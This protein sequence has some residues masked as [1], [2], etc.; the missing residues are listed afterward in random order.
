MLR[1]GCIAIMGFAAPVSLPAELPANFQLLIDEDFEGDFVIEEALDTTDDDA[2]RIF[3]SAGGNVLELRRRSDYKPPVT[4]PLSIALF[5]DVQVGSFVLEADLKQT[6]AEYGHRDMCI[7]F[8]AEDRTR[9]YYVHLASRADDSAHNVLLVDDA[10]RTAITTARTGGVS[11]GEEWHR[12]RVSRDVESGLIRVFFDDMEVP[13]MEAVDTRFAQGYVGFGSFDDTGMIDNVKLWGVAEPPRAASSSPDVAYR[14]DEAS[15]AAGKRLFEQHCR[16]CHGFTLDDIGPALGRV[17]SS[18]SHDWLHAFITDAPGIVAKGDERARRLSERFSSTMPAFRMLDTEQTE[19]LLAFIHDQRQEALVAESGNARPGGVRN[20]IPEQVQASPYT[21]VLEPWLRMPPTAS[22]EPLTRINKLDTIRG[23]S[24]TFVHDLRGVLYEVDGSEVRIYLDLR[25][26]VP[27]MTDIP[28]LGTGFGSFAFHPEFAD[29]GKLYTTHTEVRYGTA[30]DF[31]LAGD[32]PDGL[33]WIVSE[34]TAADP[35]AGRFAGTRRELLRADMIGSAHGFQ[36]LTFNPLA[37]PGSPDYGM[38]Y[39]G[40]GDGGAGFALR[41]DLLQD[42]GKVWGS[43]LRIDPAGGDSANGKYGIPPDN[44]WVG[45]PG[46]LG[47]LW[48]RGFRNPHRI[49]W[50][51][52]GSGKM[53]IADIGHHNIEE[54]NLGAAGGNYGW[55]LREGTFAFDMHG[56]QAVVYPLSDDD[57]DAYVDPV[58]QFDHDE[59]VAVSGGFV[60]AGRALEGL[61]GKYL[62]GGIVSGRVFYVDVAG[63]VQGTQAR[64]HSL[65]LEVAGEATDLRSLVGERVDLRFGLD[66]AGELVLMSKASGQL[67]KVIAV[68]RD[69]S[70]QGDSRG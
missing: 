42:P 66:A 64:I 8:G 36:E 49:S 67:W 12:V 44:P 57:D 9:F 1:V 25:A 40:V 65:A 43:I 13:V 47:E 70:W 37:E 3:A 33:Q 10:P 69:P 59:A 23:S 51:P 35:E 31:A 17:T 50:D 52:N 41:D 16:A 20:P 18:A 55:P 62:F 46:A 24:R 60:Y 28:G 54:V 63:L 38:L 6:G 15:I 34:W 45:Q 68:R 56:D 19:S 7:F 61:Q 5:R 11:W 30:A 14:T 27:E 4:S 39:L 32:V 2:W 29:N 22:I 53:L 21:L 48:A 58:I 26:E